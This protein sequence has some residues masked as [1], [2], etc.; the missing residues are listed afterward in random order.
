VKG[1]FE[2]VGIPWCVVKDC[3]GHRILLLFLNISLVYKK[4]PRVKNRG[5]PNKPIHKSGSISLRS[6]PGDNC[7]YEKEKAYM[8]NKTIFIR[9]FGDRYLTSGWLN[10]IS[11][12]LLY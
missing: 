10:L 8:K 9:P 4:N 5:L 12:L 1:F 6:G 7:L 3:L 2:W 11:D